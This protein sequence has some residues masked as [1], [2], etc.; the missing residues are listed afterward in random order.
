MALIMVIPNNDCHTRVQL[1]IK[2]F[3]DRDSNR[4]KAHAYQI[5]FIQNG[6]KLVDITNIPQ[7]GKHRITSNPFRLYMKNPENK[8]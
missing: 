5:S 7:K 2:N 1:E 8:E 6:N 4:P 3:Y